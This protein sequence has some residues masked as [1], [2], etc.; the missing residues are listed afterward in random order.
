M[1][2]DILGIFITV[3]PALFVRTRRILLRN[4]AARGREGIAL[5]KTALGNPRIPLSSG[6][7]GVQARFREAS[8]PAPPRMY[9]VETGN[10]EAL[11]LAG[12]NRTVMM[13]RAGAQP[14]RLGAVRRGNPRNPVE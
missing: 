1:V 8:L 13:R 7:Q 3:I 10:L 2:I 6:I 14:Y 9:R 11:Y 5:A 12:K 4:P